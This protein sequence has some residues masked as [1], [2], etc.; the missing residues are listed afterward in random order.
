MITFQRWL[1]V[2]AASAISGE[3]GIP[4]THGVT[5]RQQSCLFRRGA[6]SNRASDDVPDGDF[7]VYAAASG[8]RDQPLA[9]IAITAARIG[10]V[11]RLG[12]QGQFAGAELPADGSTWTPRRRAVRPVRR[13]NAKCGRTVHAYVA[14]GHSHRVTLI[15][16]RRRSSTPLHL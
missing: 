9:P 13:G 7:L 12:P 4:A 6:G 16:S 15:M 2:A 14:V 3:E 5:F 8:G 11:G 1:D 10:S